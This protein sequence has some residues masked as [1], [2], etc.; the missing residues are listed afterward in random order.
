MKRDPSLPP[1]IV[2]RRLSPHQQNAA[3]PAPAFHARAHVEVVD[4]GGQR[5]G[6]VQA[7]AAQ[8]PIDGWWRPGSNGAYLRQQLEMPV[9]LVRLGFDVLQ[10]LSHAKRLST[11]WGW[12]PTKACCPTSVPCLTC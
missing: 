11:G 12:S 1:Q 5:R 7:I 6:R 8:R 2:A 9:V 3:R 4:V 10:A